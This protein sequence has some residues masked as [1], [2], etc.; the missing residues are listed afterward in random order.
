MTGST[1]RSVWE[2]AAAG[3]FVLVTKDEDF[4]RMAV[5]LGPPPKIVWI[6]LGN[7]TTGRSLDYCAFASRKSEPSWITRRRP[8]SRLGEAVYP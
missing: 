7:C 6:R 1:D 8:S 2:R 4:H 3:G 5:L